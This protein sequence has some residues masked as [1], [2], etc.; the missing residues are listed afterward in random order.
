MVKE[1]EVKD[2]KVKLVIMM[3]NKYNEKG[4]EEYI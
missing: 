1:K 2:K 3:C 4:W